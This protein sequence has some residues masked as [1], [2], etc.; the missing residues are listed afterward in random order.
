MHCRDC[1]RFNPETRHCRDDKVN[2]QSWEDAVNVA[3][4]YGIRAICMM[5][6]HREKLVL[7]RCPR[8]PSPVNRG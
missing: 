3:N 4:A 6:D 8:K 1:S 2:P 5:N 7:S